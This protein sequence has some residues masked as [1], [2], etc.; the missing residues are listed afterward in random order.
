MANK[1]WQTMFRVERLSDNRYYVI[2]NKTG[3]KVFSESRQYGYSGYRDACRGAAQKF[4]ALQRAI[5][6]NLLGV[7]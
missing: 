7:D 2:D 1:P 5:E 4:N 3:E 6:K